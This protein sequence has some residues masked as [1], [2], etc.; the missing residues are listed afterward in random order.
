MDLKYLFLAYLFI[1]TAIFVFM[2]RI[3]KKLTFLKRNVDVK[4]DE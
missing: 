3:A 1:W 4:S 2:L